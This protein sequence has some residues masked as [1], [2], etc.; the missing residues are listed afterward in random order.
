MAA[1]KTRDGA[2]QN[3]SAFVRSL[4][5]AMP[6]KDVARAAKARGMDMAVAYVHSIRAAARRAARRGPVFGA[7]GS[8]AVVGRG[9]AQEDLLRAVAAELGLSRA[10]MEAER[11]KVRAM[12]GAW[13]AVSSQRAP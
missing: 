1:R 4:P 5:A 11:A 2:R 9:A 13:E 8:G 6:A 12:L 10:L 3:K 7:P